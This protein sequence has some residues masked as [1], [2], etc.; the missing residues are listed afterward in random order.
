MSGTI[1]SQVSHLDK[2]G[3]NAIA[4]HT[5]MG[6]I[7]AALLFG[8]AL[9]VVRTALEDQTLRAELPGYAEFAQRTRYHLLPGVW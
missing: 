5:F 7:V 9:F 2:Y 8:T 3:I 6:I 1:T 4:R